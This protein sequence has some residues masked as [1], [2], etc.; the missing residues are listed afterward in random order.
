M[1][2]SEAGTKVLLLGGHTDKRCADKRILFDV[3]N[4]RLALD[5]TLARRGNS[6]LPCLYRLQRDGTGKDG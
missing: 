6:M 5:L 2:G 1:L 4:A 3:P